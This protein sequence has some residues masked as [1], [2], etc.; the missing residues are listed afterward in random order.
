[1][2]TEY[3]QPMVSRRATQRKIRHNEHGTELRKTHSRLAEPK[4]DYS[5]TYWPVLEESTIE[6]EPIKVSQKK[7]I[8]GSR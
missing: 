8:K 1:M 2:G 7:Q 6:K 4:H 3:R 5:M